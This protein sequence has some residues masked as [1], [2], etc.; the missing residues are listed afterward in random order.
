LRADSDAECWASA[1]DFVV[2]ALAWWDGMLGHVKGGLEAAGDTPRNKELTRR[3]HP[4]SCTSR[5][6]GNARLDSTSGRVYVRVERGGVVVIARHDVVWCYI[7]C[8]VL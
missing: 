1:L 5:E 3:T 2:S 7:K 4:I 6:V 8:E